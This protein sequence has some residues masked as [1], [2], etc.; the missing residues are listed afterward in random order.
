MDCNNERTFCILRLLISGSPL[1]ADLAPW[2]RGEWQEGELNIRTGVIGRK[3]GVT[4]LWLKSGRK[5]M[6]TMVQV[7]DNHVIRYDPPEKANES[8]VMQKKA[9]PIVWDRQAYHT[10]YINFNKQLVLICLFTISAIFEICLLVPGYNLR[11]NI[12]FLIL[13][14]IRARTSGGCLSAR[15]P[16]TR[17]STPAP[18]AGCSRRRG[19]CRRRS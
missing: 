15:S 19:W 1:R 14:G 2:P 8:I 9:V 12:Y 13:S 10:Q 18:T 16:A 6:C 5:V 7:E 17:R 11:S 4:P 3:I